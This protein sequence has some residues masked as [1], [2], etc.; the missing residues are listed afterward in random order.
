MHKPDQ[1]IDSLEEIENILSRLAPSAMSERAARANDSMIDNL[2][3]EEQCALERPLNRQRWWQAGIA[4]A[5]MAGAGFAF[6]RQDASDSK[7]L[8]ATNQTESSEQIS[9]EMWIEEEN[10]ALFSA[11]SYKE[12]HSQEL[13]DVKNGFI[14]HAGLREEGDVFENASKF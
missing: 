2:V 3:K 8:V 10:G 1:Q 5:L 14:I 11:I 6:F 4:A 12:E 9:E 13:I 7:S